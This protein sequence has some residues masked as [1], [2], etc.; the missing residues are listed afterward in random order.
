MMA[1]DRNVQWGAYIFHAEMVFSIS[2][3]PKT[4][5]RAACSGLPAWNTA[6][7]SIA[8]VKVSGNQSNAYTF[9][10]CGSSC[11]VLY[12]FASIHPTYLHVDV[13]SKHPTISI[14]R[15][16]LFTLQHFS[17]DL[18]SCSQTPIKFGNG[19]SNL[20]T[21]RSQ[22]TRYNWYRL[23]VYTIGTT[24]MVQLETEKDRRPTSPND[25]FMGHMYA[26]KYLVSYLHAHITQPPSPSASMPSSRISTCQFKFSR[27]FSACSP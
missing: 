21:T 26:L 13:V 23:L 5:R 4:I 15:I 27:K 16:G 9:C 25:V 14:S 11:P 24:D 20:H 17:S 12:I 19:T 1:E 2:P 8:H 7:R 22:C 18:T 6:A 3:M 10:I